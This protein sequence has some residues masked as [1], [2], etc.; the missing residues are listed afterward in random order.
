[1]TPEMAEY[2]RA[3]LLV[4]IRDKL[5]AAFDHAL[6]TEEPLSDLILDLSG[7]ISDDEKVLSVLREYTLDHPF[8]ARVVC[9]LIR[10]DIRGRY[11]A[12]EMTRAQ[13]AG[14]LYRI[15]MALDK[16]WE[17]PWRDLTDGAYDLELLEDGQISVEVF[18]RCFDAWFFEG[19]RLNAWEV[20]RQLRHDEKA[21][22]PENI[23][24]N[25]T[26][27]DKKLTNLLLWVF[28]AAA[29]VLTALPWCVKMRF[30]SGPGEYFFEY[31]SGFSLIPAGYAM[32]SPM[33]TG[34]CAIVLT[35]MGLIYS[36]KEQPRLLKWMMSI[37]IAA[38]L[39]SVT[40]LAFGTMTIVGL[41]VAA[42]LGAEAVLL[43]HLRLET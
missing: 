31:F 33:V 10:E 2:F 17:E 7:C 21:P 3:M 4:G 14:L 9:D 32:W 42:A 23:E 30:A 18:N 37:V 40:P 12:G 6:E 11:L 16:F 22:V 24:E 41:L 34:I 8:D 5:D 35:V 25:K 19:R 29:V 38:V 39:M 27:N 15:V 13:A 43:Y 36:R 28:P 20:Q 1:M 26:M